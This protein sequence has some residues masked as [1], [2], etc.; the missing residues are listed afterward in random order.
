MV[1]N[2]VKKNSNL[3]NIDTCGLNNTCDSLSNKSSDYSATNCLST[4][5]N[6]NL[7]Q[8]G[9][10][11]TINCNRNENFIIYH[12]NIRGLSNKSKE[13]L[14]LWSIPFPQILCFTDHH[15]N[16]NEVCSIPISSYKLGSYNCWK[17]CKGGG[18]CIYVH[19][20]IPFTPINLSKVCKDK[21]IEICAIKLYQ[22]PANLCVLSIEKSP[23]GN[24][25]KFLDS[26]DSVLNFLFSNSINL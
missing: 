11:N 7:D 10:N 12:Q 9:S 22:L 19:E 17:L 15:L 21:E 6:V 13:I 18:V 4:L 3:Y 23:S 14:N 16:N 1:T 8:I 24:F 20:S 5:S 2:N 26:L 25:S